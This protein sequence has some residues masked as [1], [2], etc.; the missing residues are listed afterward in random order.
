MVDADVEIAGLIEKG[1]LLTLT[2]EE[3]L[4]HGVADHRAED[5]RELLTVLG[6]AG[7]EVVRARENWAERVVRFLTNPA[8]ASLLMTLGLLGVFVELRTPGFG[9]P[10]FV[11]VLSLAS[12]FWGHWLVALVGWEQLLLVVV[13]VVLLALEVFAI[14]GF[15]VAGVLGIA[16]LVAGLSSSLF[17]AGASA[18]AVVHAVLRVAISA[19]LSVVVGLVLWRFMRTL[20]FGRRL[21]LG[22][23]LAG[24]PRAEPEELPSLEGVIGTTL[25][26]L[27]PAGIASLAG[28]RVDVVSL[29]DFIAAGEPVEVVRDEGNRVLVKLHRPS[30][31]KEATL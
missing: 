31:R 27:R 26:P 10:G 17:G 15:G 2:T 28:R 7:A 29:G 23:T 11:G 14:P 13:G 1:K 3:A 12:F 16:A 20:P 24:G 8:V 21:V 25:T 5:T 19:A 22:T 6:H 18:G 30:E 9:I 4:R